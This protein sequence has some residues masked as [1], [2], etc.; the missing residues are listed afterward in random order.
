MKQKKFFTKKGEAQPYLNAF[1]LHLRR[2][3]QVA[4]K[5]GRK[6]TAVVVISQIVS[7]DAFA[8]REQELICCVYSFPFN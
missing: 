3:D 8:Q 7:L 4:S 5:N 2:I 1:T 6:P